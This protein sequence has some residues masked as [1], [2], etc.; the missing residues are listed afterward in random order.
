MISILAALLSAALFAV[1]T[2]LQRAAASR[3]PV[4][5]S[6]PLHLL[7]RLVTDRSWLAGG[8]IGLAALGLHALALAR[9]AVM[10]VQSVMALGL[11]L[12]L[13]GEAVRERRRPLPGE[14]GGALL[15]VA[16]VVAVVSAG[17]HHGPDLGPGAG[18]G[19]AGLAGLA[20]PAI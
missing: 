12:A 5:G 8:V 15:V 13:A 9:G 14:L 7:R 4:A 17:H 16:G 2:N 11:V 10:A 1:T 19:L 6:G 20:G 3:V 18:A